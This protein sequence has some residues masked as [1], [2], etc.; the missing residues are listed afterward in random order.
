ML[1]V[2]SILVSKDLDPFGNKDLWPCSFSRHPFLSTINFLCFFSIGFSTFLGMIVLAFASSE[3]FRIFFRMFLGIVLFGLLH[4]LCILPVYL[5]L[6]CWRRAV[7]KPHS[8]RVSVE[9]LEGRA[10]DNEDAPVENCGKVNSEGPVKSGDLGSASSNEGFELNEQVKPMDGNV[11]EQQTSQEGE[12]D[13]ERKVEDTGS[14]N[15]VFPAHSSENTNEKQESSVEE[16][17]NTESGKKDLDTELN[18]LEEEL[19]SKDLAASE[20]NVSDASTKL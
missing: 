4:G 5:S 19:A 10:A 2:Y 18:E 1:S 7:T 13:G 12:K 20:D 15:D 9:S 17:Q 6:F 14:Q 16:E 11:T 8:G 3:I